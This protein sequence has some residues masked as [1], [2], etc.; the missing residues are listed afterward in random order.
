MAIKINVSPKDQE[1]LN[2]VL[3][4][5][6][7]APQR[8]KFHCTVGF[9]EKMIPEAEAQAFG[10]IITQKLQDYIAPHIPVYEVEK[11]VHLFGHV[12]AF[13]PTAQSLA[14]LKEINLWLFEQVR[15]ISGERWG[16]NEETCPHNYFPHLTLWR[17]RHP[18][19]HLK[20]LE[21]IA[22][23]RPSYSLTQAACVL[24]AQ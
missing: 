19:P 7:Y 13:L 22:E 17:T 8:R 12:V 15:E 1:A 16:L 10:D 14:T 6:G 23:G 18:G 4:K 2:Q 3:E 9:I 20:K 11:A 5:A 24:F 21:A